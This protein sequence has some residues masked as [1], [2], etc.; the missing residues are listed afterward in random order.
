MFACI[1]SQN[2]IRAFQKRQDERDQQILNLLEHGTDLDAVAKRFKVSFA[3][4][5]AL[6][7][8]LEGWGGR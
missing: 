5:K 3:H 7:K 8:E 6:A 4:V 2:T 1:Q